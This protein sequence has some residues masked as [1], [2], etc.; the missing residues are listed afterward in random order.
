MNHATQADDPMTTQAEQLN[1]N[2]MDTWLVENDHKV[3][4]NL[5]ESSVQDIRLRDVLPDIGSEHWIHALSLGNNSTWGSPRL[6]AAVAASYHSLAADRVLVTAGVSE[7]VVTVSLAHQQAGAN[8]VIPVPAFHALYDVPEALGY[9]IRKIALRPEQGFQLPVDEVIGAI[10]AHTRIVLLNTPHNPT[11]TVYAPEDILRIADA[12]EKVGAVVVVDEHYRYLTRDPAQDC[13]ASAAGLRRNIVAFGSV[14]KCFG[15]TGLR[16]GWIIAEPA[17]LARYHHFKLLV[18]HTIPLL[19]DQLGAELLE[20]RHTILPATI[21]TITHNL[22][23]LRQVATNSGGAIDFTDPDGGSTVFARLRDSTD[24]MSFAQALLDRSGVL[25][26][27]GESFDL[28]GFFRIRLG[29]T[30][31]E[32]EQACQALETALL[33]HLPAQKRA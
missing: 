14:G 11:G 8:L 12:A 26:L 19:S 7:A 21:A 24:S 25:V 3:R 1:T 28:P 32:F 5:G 15:C 29:V 22:Q 30:P 18:T 2:I 33:E 4:I 23:R 16:V 9:E 17:L 20:R 13:I 10:D 27:P 31:A 6:R